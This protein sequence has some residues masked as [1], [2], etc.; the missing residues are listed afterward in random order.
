MASYRWK[1]R[2]LLRAR[3]ATVQITGY[4]AATTYSLTRNAKTVSVLAAGSVNATAAALA[5]AWEASTEPE[6]VEITASSAT[7][8]VTMTNDTAG[9]EWGT[10]TPAVSGG[11]GTIGALT[12]T[13]ANSGPA[14]V[15]IAA[16]YDGNAVPAGG[17]T[18]K[19]DNSDRPL[20][21]SLD[22][23]GAGTLTLLQIDQSMEGDVGLA[24]LN[25]EA[26]EYLEDRQRYYKIRAT[27]VIV[28]RG[29]GGGAGRILLDQDSVQT[30]VLVEGSGS[31]E[32]RDLEAVL[33]KGTHASNVMVVRGD[34]SVG[35]A[36]YG[37]E[38]A[39]LAT[40]TVHDNATVRIGAGV[41]LAAVV[42]YGGEVTINCAVT[43][44]IVMY[45]GTV[46]V[47]G[48]GAVALAQV[49]GGTLFYNTTGTLGG[50][51]VVGENG[52]IDFSED[53]R[54]KTVTNPID[55]FCNNPVNDPD[56]LVSGLVIDYN[57]LATPIPE[58]GVNLRLTRGATA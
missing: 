6:L 47:N 14:D 40:L 51:T 46:R 19:I 4:D 21:Y 24:E 35:V 44:S 31:P 28:G 15:S 37:G 52:R 11:A 53:P 50:A 30:S 16:N 18:L 26:D 54:A 32:D 42:V 17:D 2:A 23:S 20:L 8:T 55:A 39:T 49:W 57:G 9:V 13:T 58:L 33:W 27:T 38:V 48:T 56:K 7:D 3:V 1:G 36:V 10:I 41:T 43:T 22:Q 45:G 12:T 29:P 34:A 25:K 5:A